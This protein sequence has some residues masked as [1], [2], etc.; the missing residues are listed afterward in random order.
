MEGKEVFMMEV[1]LCV[2]NC[3][4]EGGGC[5]CAGRK[6]SLNSSLEAWNSV[7]R[8]GLQVT[9][10]GLDHDVQSRVRMGLRLGRLAGARSQWSVGS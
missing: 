7:V 2:S 8:V 5:G 1:T 10:L 6:N 4:K 3:E 9:F